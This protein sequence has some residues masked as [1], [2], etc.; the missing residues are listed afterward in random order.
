MV[1]K[2]IV[3][4]FTSILIHLINKTHGCYGYVEYVKEIFK[5]CSAKNGQCNGGHWSC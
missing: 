5:T 3:L 1:N 4:N 2:T